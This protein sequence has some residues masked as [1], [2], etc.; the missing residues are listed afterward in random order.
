[1]KSIILTIALAVI[2]AFSIAQP[3]PKSNT[4]SYS[5]ITND[6]KASIGMNNPSMVAVKVAKVPGEK[7]KIRVKGNHE[8]LYQKSYKNYATV[9]MS[10]DISELPIGEYTFELVKGNEVVY[11]QTILREPKTDDL[12][13]R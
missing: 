5:Y 7:V 1:M 12:A 6:L 4:G 3:A 11:S 13:Q 10:Y 2:T 8:V 9:D